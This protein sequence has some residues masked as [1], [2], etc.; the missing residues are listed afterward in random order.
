MCLNVQKNF[1]KLIH[2]LHAEIRRKISLNNEEYKLVA[3]VHRR[4]KEFNVGE[5]VMV[6]IHPERI[7]KTFPKNFMQEP[8]ALILSFI[9]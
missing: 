5:Y 1:A 9:N 8:W 3:D 6:R 4:S 2:D 7:P